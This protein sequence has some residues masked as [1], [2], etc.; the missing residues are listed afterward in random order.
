MSTETGGNNGDLSVVPKLQVA[1]DQS[2]IVNK[3]ENSPKEFHSPAT[4]ST[5]ATEDN[6]DLLRKEL[7]RLKLRL[8]EERKKLN[9]VS[10]RLCHRSVTN[11]WP[12][13]PIVRLSLTDLLL[14]DS[15]NSCQPLRFHSQ[16]K[17]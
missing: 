7:E 3:S 2:Q 11:V 9:D 15:F 5:T 17:Y 8:E 12:I 16:F 1:T 6:V 4:I 14:F 13:C 10:C